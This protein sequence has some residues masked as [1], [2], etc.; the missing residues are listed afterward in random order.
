M[1]GLPYLL[2]DEDPKNPEK[3]D[4]TW[5]FLKELDQYI[6]Y[7][8]TGTGVTFKEL[9]EGTRDMLASHLG[10]DMNQRILE[11]IPADYQGSF[12]DGQTFI[13]DAHFACLPKGLDD[14]RKNATLNLI[15]WLMQPE[16]QAITYDAGYFY[17]GPAIKGVTID[18]APAQSKEQV[19]AAM[20]PEYED[21]INKFA[22]TT[23]LAPADLVKA[24]DMWD[25]KIGAGK[26]Q[27]Q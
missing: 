19:S 13:N 7:Y 26:F 24:Y 3:W 2:G 8:P 4:K 6:E 11:T 10:W 16:M 23:Q 18:M 22:N 17:P 25:Q 9:G 1:M 20:R 5:A 14:D 27:V 12:F 21:A 15:D